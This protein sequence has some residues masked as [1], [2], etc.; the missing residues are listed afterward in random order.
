MAGFDNLPR[1]TTNGH[2]ELNVFELD[3]S[4]FYSTWLYPSFL[5]VVSPF[6]CLSHCHSCCIPFVDYLISTSKHILQ[7]LQTHKKRST[8]PSSTGQ[9]AWQ[10]SSLHREATDLWQSFVPQAIAWRIKAMLPCCA[11]DL[12]IKSLESLC[13]QIY[14]HIYIYIHITCIWS[15]V[16]LQL[17]IYSIV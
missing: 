8:C 3:K 13:I 5:W 16:H 7:P 1:T 9:G 14:T 6:C 12:S 15:S 11:S 2:G 17:Y 10:I 4:M